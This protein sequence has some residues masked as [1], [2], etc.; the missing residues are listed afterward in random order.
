MRNLVDL[1]THGLDAERS[2]DLSWSPDGKNLAFFSYKDPNYRLWVVPAKGGELL[3]LAKDD[4][5]DKFYLYWSPD[6]KKLSYASYRFVRVR[7]GAIWEADVEE[8]LS[9]ME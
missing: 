9:K 6:G 3:E 8:L 7:T 1:V 2:W 5:A 4:P